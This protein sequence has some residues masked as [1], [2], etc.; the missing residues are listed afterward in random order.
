MVNF[1]VVSAEERVQSEEALRSRRTPTPLVLGGSAPAS[2]EMASSPK[3]C[4]ARND[5]LP[6]PIPTSLSDSV[7]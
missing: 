2:G 5:L 4:L 1:G 6:I 3:A 7:Q